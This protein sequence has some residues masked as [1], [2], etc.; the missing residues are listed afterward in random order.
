MKKT[1]KKQVPEHTQHTE[2][3]HEKKKHNIS[4]GMIQN[5]QTNKQT[6]KQTG[7]SSNENF[8]IFKSRTK[9]N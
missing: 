9:E 7:N 3:T 2:T 4:L 5:S 6:N 8:S 1:E